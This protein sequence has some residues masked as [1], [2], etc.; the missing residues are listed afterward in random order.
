MASMSMTAQTVEAPLTPKQIKA[1]KAAA[2][3]E[4]KAKQKAEL[5]EFVKRQNDPEIG[6]DVDFVI[7]KPV[8][9]NGGDST[10]YIFGADQAK[11]LKQYMQ[12]QLGVDTAQYMVE[13]CQ[14]IQE[15]MAEKIDPTDL[16]AKAKRSGMK[17]GEQIQTMTNGFAKDYYSAE[18]DKTIDPNIVASSIIAS[19]FGA[20]EYESDYAAALFNET[21]NARKVAN[22]EMMYAPN[23]IEG[24]KW[25]AENKK[26]PGVI[27]LPSGLQYKIIEK[28]DGPIPTKTQK[29]KV[30]YEGKL[31]DGTVFD[32]SYKRNQ[33][34]TFG[35][36]QVIPGW[37]EAL[38]KMPV[39][40][41]WEIYIP[42]ELAY[43]DHE[44]GQIKPFS[45]LIFNVELLGIEEGT[46]AKKAA[47]T[48]P[49]VGSAT[50]KTVTAT[51]KA[52]T[53]TTK[54]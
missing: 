31:I 6:A 38:C 46:T 9:A 34:A 11:G 1:K 26:L 13:F 19:L 49:K 24:E 4:F 17:I 10:A 50:S 22:T 27:T 15:K 8:L 21:M 43:G 16:K 41:K 48:T 29:V 23:R 32:S 54:K 33:P 53:V 42:Q 52:G 25:L 28:G 39:G 3:K 7:E 36:S 20:N 12:Q 14:G 30:N 35:V 37:T 44:T 51:P 2:L 45:A 5:A 47:T 40:S 18:P